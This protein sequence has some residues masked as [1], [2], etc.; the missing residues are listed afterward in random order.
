MTRVPTIHDLLYL[1]RRLI[2]SNGGADGVL[3]IGVLAG[4]A[5]QPLMTFDGR[6]LYES[7]FEKCAALGFAIIQNH[8]F[9]DG[10]KRVGHAAIELM[11]M[12]NGYRLDAD[13]EDAEALILRV[14]SGQCAREELVAWIATHAATH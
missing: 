11:L 7:L 3:N 14:A 12:L 8:P 10:N 6:D 1:H 13:V 4:A 5:A 2:E 9:A